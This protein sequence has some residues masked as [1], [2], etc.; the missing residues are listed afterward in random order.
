MGRKGSKK[1]R[2]TDAH[3]QQ[4]DTSSQSANG[5]SRRWIAMLLGFSTACLVVIAGVFLLVHHP[6]QPNQSSHEESGYVDPAACAGCHQDVAESFT[7]TGMA[8]SL[9]KPDAPKMVEDFTGAKSYLHRAT[10]NYYV[11]LHKPDGYYIKRYQLGYDGNQTNVVE[12]RIDY[13]IGSGD[14]ARSYLHRDGE[15]HLIEL[16]ITWYT[17]Q[18]GYWAMSPNYD[19]RDQKDMHG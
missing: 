10:G 19:G 7:H 18:G 4:R 13:V 16:P 1:L 15:G 12:E 6:H 8:H 9:Y 11:A 3:P 14:Q 5:D 17:E 2:T